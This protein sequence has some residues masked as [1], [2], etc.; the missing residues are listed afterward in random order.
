MEDP[1]HQYGAAG[2]YNVSLIVTSD[3]GCVDT[4][5]NSTEIY[6]GPNAAFSN[7]PEFANVFQNVNFTDLSTSTFP[8]VSWLWDFADG[9]T[10]SDQNTSYNFSEG[11]DYNVILIVEDD[12][13]CVD[14]ANNVV[15]IYLPP[16]VP[17]G[18]SPNGDNSNDFLF[19]YGGPF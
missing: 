8:I 18:F 16:L 11:G 12:N 14:T 13:G 6:P 4:V 9:N 10:S 15:Y 3:Q 7:E 19:V 17:S 2:I 1:L 5:S